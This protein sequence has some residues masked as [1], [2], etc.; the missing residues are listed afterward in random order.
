MRLVRLNFECLEFGTTSNKKN[1]KRNSN[2]LVDI[3]NNLL[4]YYFEDNLL[5]V[6]E[7]E[8]KLTNVE[9]C[10]WSNSN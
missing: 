6:R 3:F 8:N 7:I 1:N 10:F 4:Y 2:L 5:S 9:L